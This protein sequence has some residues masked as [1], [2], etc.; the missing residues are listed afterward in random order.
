MANPVFSNSPVFRD[1]ALQRPGRDAS[2]T[3][4]GTYGAPAARPDVPGWV[5]GPED[6]G[7]DAVGRLR[8]DRAYLV[9]PDGFVVA[10]V[11]VRDGVVDAA[12][13]GAALVAHHVLR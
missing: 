4:A 9:R 10:S 8:P 12:T 5:D 3:S 13:L 11:P 6:F 7:R 1:P 2:V